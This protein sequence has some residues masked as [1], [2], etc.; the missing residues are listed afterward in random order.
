MLY[1]IAAQCSM[2]L[3]MCKHL[4]SDKL[5]KVKAIKFGKVKIVCIWYVF[6]VCCGKGDSYK[7]NF[8]LKDP[9]MSYRRNTVFLILLFSYLFCPQRSRKVPQEYIVSLQY[10][11]YIY[12]FPILA[13]VQHLCRNNQFLL[14]CRYLHGEI[15]N[16]ILLQ[17]SF[18]MY[19]QYS[20]FLFQFLFQYILMYIRLIHQQHLLQHIF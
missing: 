7:D 8:F 4:H 12:F 1:I 11:C 18:S 10:L 3:A 13:L 5:F 2:F 15:I 16:L 20:H 19:L 6:T 14:I 9:S 17:Q